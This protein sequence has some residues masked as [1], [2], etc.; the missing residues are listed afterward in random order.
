MSDN[1]N[2]NLELSGSTDL[3][4]NSPPMSPPRIKPY[5]IIHD[6]STSDQYK[7]H[8][9]QKLSENEEDKDK[10]TETKILQKFHKKPLKKPRSFFGYVI[11]GTI[12]GIAAGTAIYFNGS[13]TAD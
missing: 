11:G 9:P 8:P 10:D 7:L 12:L 4:T 13:S 1:E 2:K 3:A 6:Y 5:Y